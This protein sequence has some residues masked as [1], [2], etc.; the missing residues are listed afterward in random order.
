M[1]TMKN[2]FVKK[3]KKKQDFDL[4][5][6]QIRGETDLRGGYMPSE[7]RQKIFQLNQSRPNQKFL[8]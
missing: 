7:A 8:G 1:Y 6:G 3:R 4:K 2:Q 5:V